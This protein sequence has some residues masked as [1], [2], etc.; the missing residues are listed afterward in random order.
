MSVIGSVAVPLGDRAY[1]V[2]VGHGLIAEAPKHLADVLA[3]P[4]AA[5][6]TDA[7]VAQLYLPSLERAFEEAGIQTT[8]V[9][10]P[11]GEASKDF[12]HLELVL[13]R[14][15]DARIERGDTV[16]ALGGGVVG[17][18]GGFAASVLRRGA[19]VVQIPTTLLA[20]VDAAV[21][22]KTGINTRQGK[23][24]VGA[25]HQP[26]RVVADIAALDT[27]SPREFRAGYAE[28]VKYG[29]L[30][31]ARL[32]EWLE[33]HYRKILDGDPGARGRA[34]LASVRAK[35]D[36][37][38]RDER[39]TGARAL[40]NLGHTF[41][42]ALEAELGYD[43]RI[44]HGEAVAAGLALAFDLSVQLGFCP[45]EDARRVRRHLALSGLPTGLPSGVPWDPLRLMTHVRQ[46]KKVSNRKLAFV[47]AHGIGRSF[48]SRD[49]SEGDVMRVL[50]A[51]P[52]T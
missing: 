10:V 7:T 24:L 14:L 48:V 40:L 36:I 17:D 34:V 29:L 19:A 22:G 43:G 33:A 41:G 30:G 6:V 13:D 28:V 45:A 31:D 35:A 38:A 9:V 50:E 52:A 47:L 27:L 5:I 12:A 37:V 39:E 11:P 18:L 51:A 32:F 46:D 25:F 49:V 4:R 16:C 20:Q 21:G 8:A 15:L 44:L 23:N 1:D 26:R 2:V 3:R 42:H